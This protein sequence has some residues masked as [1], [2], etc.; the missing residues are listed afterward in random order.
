MTGDNSSSA[1][2]FAQPGVIYNAWTTQEGLESW[3]LRL[4]EFTTE[5]GGVRKK[6]RPYKKEIIILAMVWLR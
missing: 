5:G 3:F 4:A 1:S 2:P 6:M